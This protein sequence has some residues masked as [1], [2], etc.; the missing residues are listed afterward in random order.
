MAWALSDAYETDIRINS[1]TLTRKEKTG[2]MRRFNS[3][4]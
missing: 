3:Y 1:G 4:L 2:M